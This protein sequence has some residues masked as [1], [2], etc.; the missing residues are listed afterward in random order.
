MVEWFEI[1]ELVATVI[2]GIGGGAVLVPVVNWVKGLLNVEGGFVVALAIFFSVVIAVAENVV[3]G[4]ITP[5]SFQ[6]SNLGVLVI[7]VYLA[8]QEIYKRYFS[9]E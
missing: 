5:D 1:L 9:G 7:T 2:V 4:V 6:L 8:S 3:A